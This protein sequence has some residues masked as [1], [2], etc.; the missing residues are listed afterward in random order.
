MKSFFYRLISPIY[1]FVIACQTV[2]M[3]YGPWSVAWHSVPSPRATVLKNT[4]GASSFKYIINLQMVTHA[5]FTQS[6]AGKPKWRSNSW[7]GIRP[8]RIVNS[9]SVLWRDM[10]LIWS[11]LISQEAENRR[12]VEKLLKV[13]SLSFLCVQL[14]W[15]LLYIY[16]I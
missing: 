12:R 2:I 15:K 3:Q 9:L 8:W 10:F 6:L 16:I 7:T 13:D 14:A 11:L 5:V 1:S 4:L